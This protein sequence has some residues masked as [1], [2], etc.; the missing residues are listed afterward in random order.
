MVQYPVVVKT[1]PKSPKTTPKINNQKQSEKCTKS[2]SSLRSQRIYSASKSFMI[3]F[4]LVN[5]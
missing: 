1:T 2:Q 4:P 5:Q 3:E